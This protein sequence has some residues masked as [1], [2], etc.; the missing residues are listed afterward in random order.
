[1]DAQPLTDMIR[2]RDL[3]YAAGQNGGTVV[4]HA[5]TGEMRK[6]DTKRAF[7]GNFDMNNATIDVNGLTPS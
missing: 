7:A 4:V 3:Q 2:R 1:M 5:Q 6:I